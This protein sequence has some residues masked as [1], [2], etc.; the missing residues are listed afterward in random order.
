MRN[1]GDRKYRYKA[2]QGIRENIEAIYE[3]LGADDG[4]R[5][6]LSKPDT[7]RGNVVSIL[8][9]ISKIDNYNKEEKRREE[10]RIELS[11]TIIGFIAHVLIWNDASKSGVE[12]IHA[13]AFVI[14]LWGLAFATVFV[15]IS[16]ERSSIF[17]SLWSFGF[18][19]VVVSIAVSALMVW[20]TGQASALINGVFTIDAAAFPYT[21]AMVTGLLAFQYAYPI[22]VFV[23]I[24]SAGAHIFMML[25]K[26]KN[27]NADIANHFPHDLPWF[28]IGFVMLTIALLYSTA[29]WVVQDFSNDE[30]PFKVYLLAHALDFDGKYSCIG[31]PPGLSVVYIGG[32][33]DKVLVD[34]NRPDTAN[35]EDFIDRHGNMLLPKQ[36]RIMP[37]A[38]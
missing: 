14:K 11:L 19:K 37:C 21:R 13:H 12:W 28:S 16:L 24:M 10:V 20:S 7:L 25:T 6:D 36:F 38:F 30:W 23:L 3:E 27:S 22:F 26:W 5:H 35:I 9:K 18:T 31:V 1:M 33:Q 17:K 4:R 2:P 8:E 29:T 15:G 32:N 34:V